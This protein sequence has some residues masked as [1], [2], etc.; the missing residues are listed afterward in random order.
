MALNLNI[1]ILLYVTVLRTAID[2][3]LNEGMTVNGHIGMGSQSQSLNKLQ[4]IGFMGWIIRLWLIVRTLTPWSFRSWAA[5]CFHL[6]IV[7]TYFSP[8]LDGDITI[9]TSL[10]L[11]RVRHSLFYAI[12]CYIC[13]RLGNVIPAYRGNLT[14]AIDT[15]TIGTMSYLGIAL[16]GDITVTTNQG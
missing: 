7:T 2:R 8:A 9:A 15:A 12:R 11:Q 3:T 16:N 13:I 14:T 10:I 6:H 1:S 5:I 4:I